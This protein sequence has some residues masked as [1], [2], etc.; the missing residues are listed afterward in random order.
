MKIGSCEDG[1]Q[2]GDL[3]G[4][5]AE[6]SDLDANKA[7][8]TDLSAANNNINLLAYG[9]SPNQYGLI[10]WASDS[11]YRRTIWKIQNYDMTGTPDDTAEWCC[12][13]FQDTAKIRGIVIAI[14]YGE[15]K[16]RIMTRPYY[17][18]SWMGNWRSLRE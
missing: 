3:S 2:N 16:S 5:N 8:K 18:G 9:I 12:L 6:I 4:L 14:E 10:N 13:N 11:P 7:S 17:K 1:K 15:I